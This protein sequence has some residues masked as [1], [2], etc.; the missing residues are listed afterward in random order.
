[1]GERD[2]FGREKGEDSLRAMGWTS[3]APETSVFAAGEAAAPFKP[4]PRPAEAPVDG[5]A[6]L[7]AD[8]APARSG[9]SYQRRIDGGIGAP[10]RAA[11]E[12]LLQRVDDAV[13]CPPEQAA[14]YL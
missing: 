10:S 7:R 1:M 5:D 13:L 6:P 9:R 11:I 8:T 14:E 12:R 3:S 4:R 2:A